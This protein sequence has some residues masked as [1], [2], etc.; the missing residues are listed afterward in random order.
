[1]KD[2]RNFGIA[3]AK[4]TALASAI[5]HAEGFG[6]TEPDG[7]P[8]LPTR[9]NNPGDLEIGDKGY[10]TESGKTIFNSEED[11]W[12]AL[13]FECALMLSGNS[14]VYSPLDTFEAVA[15]KY[16]GNDQ[17]QSWAAEVSS[18]LNLT[19]QSRLT[20]WLAA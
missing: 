17:A 3:D 2:W 6:G 10:G 18:R 9:C 12:N 7:S 19:P 1:M 20:D 15:V 11:G 8:N 4:I 16:T 5:A 14:H 13:Y